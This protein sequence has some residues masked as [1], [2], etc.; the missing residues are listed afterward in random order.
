MLEPLLKQLKHPGASMLEEP[1]FF[2]VEERERGRGGC[3][4]RKGDAWNGVL[5][6]DIRAREN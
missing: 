2:G 1:Q 5:E 6:A 3:E 4:E